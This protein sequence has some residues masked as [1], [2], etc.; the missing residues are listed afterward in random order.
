MVL[1]ASWKEELVTTQSATEELL[2][3]VATGIVQ[4]DE[5][6]IFRLKNLAATCARLAYRNGHPEA[7]SHL[8]RNLIT[9]CDH[10]D[11][12]EWRERFLV[13]LQSHPLGAPW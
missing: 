4:R 6:I 13:A 7:L 9:W 5:H 10:L 12:Q 2:V 3:Q 1:F 11:E 8:V